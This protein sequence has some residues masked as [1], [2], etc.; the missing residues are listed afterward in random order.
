MLVCPSLVYFN[1]VPGETLLEQSM[2]LGFQ[3]CVSPPRDPTNGADVITTSLGLFSSNEPRYA[4]Y[5]AMERNIQAAGIPHAIA[6]GNE[7]SPQTIRTPGNCPPPWPNPANHPTDTA[8]SAVI[9]VG[10][11]DNSDNAA[12]FT[13]QGPTVIWGTTP[14]YNDYAYPPGL[15]DPDVCAPGVDILSTYYQGDQAYTTMSGTSMATPATAGCIALMLSK[16]PNLT[17]RKVDSILEVCAVRDL[18]PSGKDNTYG[19]GRINC[20]LAVTFTPMPGPRH[21]IAL[22]S[23]IA[24]T[25]KIGPDTAL[26]PT[27]LMVNV[28]TYHETAIPVHLRIDSSGTSIYDQLVTVPSLDSVG[29]DTVRFPDWLPGPGGNV[30]DLTAWHS[31]SPDT[32]RTND[33]LRRSTATRNHDVKSASCNITDRVRA[34]QPMTPRLTL[35]DTGD[36]VERGFPATCWVDSAGVRIYDHT[37]SVDSLVPG[38]PVQV[39]F[40][41]WAVGPDSAIYSVTFFHGLGTDR[42]HRNDTL[43]RTV[44]ASSYLVRVAIEM[45]ADAPG[46]TQPNAIYRID[47]LCR[48]LGWFDS[49]VQGRDIDSLNKLS[50]YTVVITGSD[51]HAQQT[52]FASYQDAL[53]EWVQNG[54]GFVGCG[55]IVYGARSELGPNSR[56]DTVLAVRTTNYN[57]LVS[58]SVVTILDTAH[59]ITRGV[60]NFPIQ[61]FGEIAMGGVWPGTATLGSYAVASG[62]ASIAA[63]HLGSGRSIYLGPIYYGDFASYANEPYYDDPDAMLLLRQA[64]EWAALGPTAAVEEPAAGQSALEF[65]LAPV[66]PNPASGVATISYSVPRA[67]DVNITV[68]DI[69]GRTVATLVNGHQAAGRYT[70]AWNRTDC[71]GSRVASGVYFCKLTSGNYCITRKLVVE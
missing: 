33:T 36:Y 46:R 23:L 66:R 34:G 13:S 14:P 54:G 30:Y 50:N 12:S 64:L 51:G 47:S 21:D 27:L 48:S 45:K 40:P 67:L 24:P 60:H 53:L 31:F 22:T 65:A 58:D 28:G 69:S 32:D 56:M 38:S 71:D 15:T 20:S 44:L 9:T 25:G 61:A 18:G 41:N 1:S 6:A 49:I 52:D 8:T 29:T 7:A 35:S 17:P 70:V 10:A 43:Y 2:F 16:N 5:R 59:P 26:T 55:L 57:A 68:Y 11:T 4:N 3:F 42:N 63:K 37:V 19:A 39:A 62:R